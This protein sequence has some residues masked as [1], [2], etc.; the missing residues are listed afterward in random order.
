MAENG[1]PKTVKESVGSKEPAPKKKVVKNQ[2]PKRR[3]RVKLENL[4]TVDIVGEDGELFY[5][6]PHRPHGMYVLQR[7]PK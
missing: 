4:H 6:A 1:K 3:L 5:L 7:K 2:K